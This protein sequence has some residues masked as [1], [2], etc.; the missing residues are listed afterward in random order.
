MYHLDANERKRSTK[1][2]ECHR[3]A[4][5]SCKEDDHH[6]HHFPLQDAL[7][8]LSVCLSL[9]VCEKSSSRTLGGAKTQI[10]T[11]LTLNDT[12]K[13]KKTRSP[14]LPQS[15]VDRCALTLRTAHER[16]RRQTHFSHLVPSTRRHGRRVSPFFDNVP[17][18]YAC[19][20]IE[21]RFFSLQ[22]Q[23]RVDRQI[24][25][26]EEKKKCKSNETHTHTSWRRIC[27]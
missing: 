23:V 21:V 7:I 22:I 5:D 4:I 8:A 17:V 6:H 18:G 27:R 20:F 24:D 15:T 1:R 19:R 14:Y 11:S 9:G 13:A 2:L 3:S 25:D 12:Q 26:A 16:K 10:R